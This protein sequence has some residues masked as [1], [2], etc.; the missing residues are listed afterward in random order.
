MTFKEILIASCA[1]GICGLLIMPYTYGN[2]ELTFFKSATVGFLVAFF[3]V[4]LLLITI[5][6][7]VK[8][9]LRRRRW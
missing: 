7:A 2:S 3:A 1:A 5:R 4:F 6:H 8:M 9:E